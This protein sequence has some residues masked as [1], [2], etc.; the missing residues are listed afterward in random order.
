[1]GEFFDRMSGE[2]D[3]HMK[4]NVEGFEQFYSSIAAAIPET[5]AELGILDIGCGTGIE[6][7]AV[8]Q[9]VPNALITG[10]DLS[11]EML[12]ILRDKYNNYHN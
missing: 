9:R 8:F 11:G 12:D 10:V 7:A 1:M 6:L 5:K 2:Y 3:A 4:D